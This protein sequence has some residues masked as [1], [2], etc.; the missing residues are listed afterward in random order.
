MSIEVRTNSTCDLRLCQGDILRNVVHIE[1]VAHQGDYIE[2]T[3]TT[4]PRAI[5]LTQDCDLEQDFKKRILHPPK[6][7]LVS[8]LVAPL[9]VA[10]HV[11]VGEHLALLDMPMPKIE[12]ASSPGKML[13]QNET[14]RYYYLAFSKASRLPPLI[15]DF[16]H[17]FSVSVDYLRTLKPENFECRVNE[18]FRESISLRFANYLSRIGLPEA[19]A[20]EAAASQSA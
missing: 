15:I 9:Y 7:T 8:V 17:Y 13:M 12:K 18:L 2:V 5:V 11:F 16:K 20:T 10:E 14:P 6:P 4:F 19:T 1:S 3:K